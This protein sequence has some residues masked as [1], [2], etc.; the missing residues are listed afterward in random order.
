MLLVIDRE[1]D[2]TKIV[3]TSLE[4]WSW[5]KNEGCICVTTFAF[6]AWDNVHLGGTEGNVNADT[7][8]DIKKWSFALHEIIIR[9]KWMNL[10]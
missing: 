5:W 6:P 9:K 4:E 7:A 8:N 1:K 10:K 2:A 3:C